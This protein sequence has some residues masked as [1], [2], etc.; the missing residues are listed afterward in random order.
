MR[1]LDQEFT[2]DQFK[3]R[4]VLRDGQIVML[5]KR[6]WEGCRPSFEVVIVRQHQ[7]TVIHGR[8]YGERESMP[9]PESWGTLGWTYLS[10]VDA[11]RKFHQ[12]VDQFLANDQTESERA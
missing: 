3:F 10:E 11:K 9:P 6:K 1:T 8:K 4:Q 12:L 2:Y 7:A 5:E